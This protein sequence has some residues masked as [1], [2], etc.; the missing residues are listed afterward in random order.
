VSE[1]SAALGNAAPK[2]RIACGGRSY[3]VSLVD[4]AV[5]VAYEKALYQKSRAALAELKSISDKDYYE[6]KL[7]AMAA[8]FEEGGFAMES[9]FG[10][11]ALGRPGGS[12]LLLAILMGERV[13][14][15]TS[16]EITPM[17]EVA[18]INVVT[19]A[20]D[21]VGSV[22]K[23]VLVESFPGADVEKLAAGVEAAAAPEVAGPKA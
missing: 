19:Q 4:Q 2:H 9:E 12:I 17:S 7:D 5:K 15:P 11:K 3:P 13:V 23:A 20:P 6:R 21:E 1:L 8:K 14:T 18:V 16:V 22:L 10:R